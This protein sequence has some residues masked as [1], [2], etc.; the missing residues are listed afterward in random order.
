[1]ARKPINLVGQLEIAQIKLPA[2][3]IQN[4]VRK[5]FSDVSAINKYRDTL[6]SLGKDASQVS[7][8]FKGLSAGFVF[9][10]LDRT[11]IQSTNKAY[12]DFASTLQSVDRLVKS[13][14]E[15]QISSQSAARAIKSLAQNFVGAEA[16]AT[17]LNESVQA[18]GDYFQGRLISQVKTADRELKIFAQN[19]KKRAEE[20][21]KANLAR[22]K[23]DAKRLRDQ[24]KLLFKTQLNIVS[25]QKPSGILDVIS[26]KKQNLGAGPFQQFDE[27]IIKSQAAFQ[28]VLGRETRKVQTE[29]ARLNKLLERANELRR[30]GNIRFSREQ[31][32]IARKA[33]SFV[34]ADASVIARQ[35]LVG[36]DLGVS[37]KDVDTL[38]GNTKKLNKELQTFNSNTL[39]LE[40]FGKAARLAFKRYAAFV[41]GSAA[42]FAITNNLRQATSAALELEAV[43]TKIQQVLRETD[44]GLRPLRDEIRRLS[45]TLGV[46][47]KELAEGVFFFAQSGI[48]EIEDLRV[49]AQ[50]LAKVP[51]SAT[52][53]DIQSTSEGLIAT[54]GQF[55]LTAQDTGY[56]LDLVNQFAADFAVES[57]DIFEAI[58][59][60]GAAFSVAGG[61]LEQFVSLFSALREATRESASTLGTFFKSGFAQVLQGSSQQLLKQLGVQSEDLNTQIKELSDIL[62]GDGNQFTDRR[63]IEIA[64]QL[65]GE[66]QF[67]RLLA[68]L[69]QLQ[70]EDTAE[71]IQKAFQAAPGS[72]DASLVLR[73]DDI[74][75]SID[76]IRNTFNNFVSQTLETNA[77]KKFAKD[78]ADLTQTFFGLLSAIRPIIPFLA[79]LGAFKLSQGFGK[80]LKGAFPTGLPLGGIGRG[81][82]DR[83]NTD[84]DS[85]PATR[86]QRINNVINERRRRLITSATKRNALPIGGAIGF[87]AGQLLS[88]QGG[89][90]GALGEGISNTIALGAI[91]GTFA[92]PV[93]AVVGGLVGLVTSVAS[94][95]KE[96]GQRRLTQEINLALRANDPSQVLRTIATQSL[97]NSQRSLNLSQGLLGGPAPAFTNQERTSLIGRSAVN[98]I[99]KNI[100]TDGL[101][102]K[103]FVGNIRKIIADSKNVDEA[104]KKIGDALGDS[105]SELDIDNLLKGLEDLKFIDLEFKN[106]IT[107]FGNVNNRFIEF[108]NRF[109]TASRFVIDRLF[110]LD[111]NIASV[112]Q[113]LNSVITDPSAGV[114]ASAGNNTQVLRNAGLGSFEDFID[115]SVGLFNTFIAENKEIIRSFT[116]ARL[117]TQY[118]AFEDDLNSAEGFFRALAALESGDVQNISEIQSSQIQSLVDRFGEGFDKVF[119]LAGPGFDLAGLFSNLL[120]NTDTRSVLQGILPTDVFDRVAQSINGLVDSFNLELQK[121]TEL[122][123]S[124]NTIQSSIAQAGRDIIKLGTERALRLVANSLSSDQVGLLTREASIQ[125]G[126]ASSFDISSIPSLLAEI[127]RLTG[128]RNAANLAAAGANIDGAG[129]GELS[130]I[131]RAQTINE[132]YLT[133][134]SLLDSAAANLAERLSAAS[135][136]SDLL[137]RAF[138]TYRDQIRAAG[139]AVTSFG[140]VDLAKAFQA[141]DTFVS[142]SNAGGGLG[143]SAGT[144]NALNNISRDQ[145]SQLSQLLQAIGSFNIGGISGSDLL[146]NIQEQLALPFLARAR[147]AVT[148]EST[149]DATKAI[150]QQLADLQA[151]QAAAVAAEDQLRALQQQIVLTQQQNLQQD[152][153]LI[154]SQFQL[155]SDLSNVAVLQEKAANLVINALGSSFSSGST[156][157]PGQVAPVNFEGLVANLNTNIDALTGLTTNLTNSINQLVSGPGIKVDNVIN[158]SPVQVNVAL[159][160][161]DVI[162]VVGPQLKLQILR[163]ISNELSEVF[164]D[165]QEKLSRIKRLGS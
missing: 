57:S 31:D 36:G 156:S 121:R 74:G 26:G 109:N 153:Q 90:L 96:E 143:T 112:V 108:G 165:D 21:E 38:A 77:F 141:F 35:R 139:A 10:K 122:V 70:D 30:E 157:V 124:L 103:E 63:R 95:I 115:S 91:G 94:F 76:R 52:F 49:V 25:E 83:F 47:A 154:R 144:T 82:K 87:G 61:D 17:L 129:L 89:G 67:A 99:L 119:A 4:E 126:A 68:L 113:G 138:T 114:R 45:S 117:G 105:F 163:E 123:Q 56:V 136:V 84:L 9:R 102:A 66:R 140:T 51:L 72:L 98:D 53:D 107:N 161:P 128:S 11:S 162:G 18:L 54:F 79:I 125:Q 3:K 150:T 13:V 106:F 20:I 16:D 149:E 29:Q 158:V 69:R 164:Q 116:E 142:L 92:G 42:I 86:Q 41:V 132:Q 155:V 85:A 110:F 131:E 50:N 93:G 46:A 118:E 148:G 43:F 48:Q 88:Q 80:F 65:T 159:S 101:G 27:K 39:T 37:A 64:R 120:S 137:T 104:K 8:I 1:M 100:K 146:G 44:K 145:F 134:Q 151:Q 34:N 40:K 15:G 32:Q 152:E 62:F 71:R 160:I 24:K 2:A 75:K 111:K 7:N 55:N 97:K 5:A 59:R 6:R 12:K 78:V 33:K 127:T 73:L 135:S 19:E 14:F 130:T 133:T 147:S 22:Q 60:G 28:K 81:V 58:K 23:S